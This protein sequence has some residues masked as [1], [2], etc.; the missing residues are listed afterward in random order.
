MHTHVH[1]LIQYISQCNLQWL[2]L[3]IFC[4]GIT[5]YHEVNARLLCSSALAF[6]ATG[7]PLTYIAAKLA[8]G[9]NTTQIKKLHH[10]GG[11]TVFSFSKLRI[12]LYATTVC[13]SQ[14]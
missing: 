6:K 14:A 5:V 7:Y 4:S 13:L 3:L 1:T 12:V 11:K 8:L 9:S 2:L 10:S